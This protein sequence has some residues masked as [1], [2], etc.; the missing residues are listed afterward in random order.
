MYPPVDTYNAPEIPPER[1]EVC[2]IC[3]EE[4]GEIVQ[5]CSCTAIM[6]TKC[7]GHWIATS[8]SMECPQCRQELVHRIRPLP[9]ERVVHVHVQEP[10]VP[11]QREEPSRIDAEMPRPRALYGVG[12]LVM[13]QNRQGRIVGID[14]TRRPIQYGVHFEDEHRGLVPES[15]IVPIPVCRFCNDHSGPLLFNMCECRDSVL[16]FAHESCMEHAV[17][18][19]GDR[20][21]ACRGKFK[22]NPIKRLKTFFR[23]HKKVIKRCV[24]IAGICLVGIVIVFV[25]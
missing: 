6:H 3:M 14:W 12:D 7:L 22:R 20:C 23:K 10:R 21:F 19:H 18:S 16:Q 25:I 9:A 11:V 8:G 5:P 2:M 15:D 4:G 13:V 24:I 1:D 17:E